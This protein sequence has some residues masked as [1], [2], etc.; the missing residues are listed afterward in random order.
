MKK[1]YERYKHAIPLIIYGIIYLT[2]FSY[3]ERTVTHQIG[4]AHV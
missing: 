4:R 3:L 2:W 1:Y